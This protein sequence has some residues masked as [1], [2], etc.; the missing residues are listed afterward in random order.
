LPLPARPGQLSA[1]FEEMVRFLTTSEVRASRLAEAEAAEQRRLLADAERAGLDA[2]VL[3]PKVSEILPLFVRAEQLANVMRLG[4]V[5]ASVAV[6][7]LSA[8]T[9]SVAA[10]RGFLF[11]ESRWLVAA[12]IGCPLLAL[13]CLFVNRRRRWHDRWIQYRYLAEQ[14]RASMYF[15][16]LG[17]DWTPKVREAVSHLRYYG[18]PASWI[19]GMLQQLIR[20]ALLGRPGAPPAPVPAV[21]RAFIIEGWLAA[22]QRWHAGNSKAK[23]SLHRWMRAAVVGLFGVTVLLAVAHLPGLLSP[24]LHLPGDWI[25]CI[26]IVLPAWAGAIHGIG[27]QFAYERIAA[28]SGEMARILAEL[29]ERA[30]ATTSE[31]FEDVVIEAAVLSGNETFEWTALLKFEPPELVA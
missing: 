3:E 17:R 15:L 1:G 30:P 8:T 27:K 19:S 26:A 7:L 18:A 10:V 11:A 16:V 9:V 31:G 5:S 14:L 29:A 23:G 13:A 6:F 25:T 20:F 12:E 21:A 2:A 28:R 22:Q 4:H 24:A